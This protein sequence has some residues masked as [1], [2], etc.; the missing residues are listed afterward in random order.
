M[1]RVVGEENSCES[2]GA[3]ERRIKRNICQ[4]EIPQN[5]GRRFERL[6]KLISYALLNSSGTSLTH[7][8][9]SESRVR[10]RLPGTW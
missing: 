2:S 4:V 8:G 1:E 9:V 6:N 3:E 10:E 5:V 7:G